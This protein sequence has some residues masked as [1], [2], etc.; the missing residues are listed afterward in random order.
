MNITEFR[1]R[2]NLS[3]REL[4]KRLGIPQST[5]SYIESGKTKDS[6]YN[7]KIEEYLAQHNQY[8]IVTKK[9]KDI[10]KHLNVYTYTKGVLMCDE[11]NKNEKKESWF[12]KFL[13]FIGVKNV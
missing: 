12:S 1:K 10:E 2:N 13:K 6:K 3:Q 7:K 9:Y 5:L 11:D 4:A 8:Y